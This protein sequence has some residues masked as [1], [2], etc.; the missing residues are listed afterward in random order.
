VAQRRVA[1]RPDD[2]LRVRIV[3]GRDLAG[4]LQRIKPTREVRRV[5]SAREGIGPRF[6][7]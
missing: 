5:T 1:G 7:F 2:V 4:L 6:H 3:V